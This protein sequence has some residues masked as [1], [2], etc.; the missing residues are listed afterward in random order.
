[1]QV[2][3]LTSLLYFKPFP[4]DDLLVSPLPVLSLPTF[5]LPL[6]EIGLWK[7]GLPG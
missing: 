6:Y 5:C 3:L 1:M 7:S 2:A 4:L